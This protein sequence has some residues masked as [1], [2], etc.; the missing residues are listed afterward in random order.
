MLL[1]ARITAGRFVLEMMIFALKTMNF[2]LKT[3]NFV[4]QLGEHGLWDKQTE[5]ELA[6]R[7]VSTQPLPI[8]IQSCRS[9][10]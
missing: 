8:G 7:V 3:M 9:V 6:T 10:E 4:S 1:S 5:F 2:A